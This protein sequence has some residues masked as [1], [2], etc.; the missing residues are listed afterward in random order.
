MELANTSLAT[1]ILSAYAFS[2]SNTDN[3]KKVQRKRMN[4]WEQPTIFR[5]SFSLNWMIHAEAL[6]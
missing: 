6:P 3:I 2:R 1:E 5:I 4:M